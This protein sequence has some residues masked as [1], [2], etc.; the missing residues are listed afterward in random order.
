MRAIV[1][2]GQSGSGKTAIA[3][4]TA[5]KLS[6]NGYRVSYYKPLGFQKRTGK[7]EDDDVQLMKKVLG[8]HFSADVI[9]PVRLAPGYLSNLTN[10]TTETCLEKLDRCFRQLQQESQ[11][12][13]IEGSI[14]PFTGGSLGMDDYN[15]ALR[16]EAPVLHVIRADTDF[17]FDSALFHVNYSIN[18][19]IPILGCIFNNTLQAQWEKT[20]NLYKNLVE[21]MGIT[22]MG[23]LPHQ[24]VIA[25]PTVAEFY[26]A[27]GG[28][29]LIG[30][31]MLDRQVENIVVGAMT[32]ESALTYLRRSINTAVITGG[33]R[34][35]I[36]LTAL[37]TNTSVLIL[38][39]GHYP[40]VQIIARA[41]EKAVPVILV[42]YD[43]FTTLENLHTVYHSITPNSTEAIQ[44]IKNDS[45]RYLNLDPLLELLR[46]NG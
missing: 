26:Q 38:T 41:E 4:A 28:E 14:D 36:A 24:R 43:T 13:I 12:V 2:S 15:L 23:V 42:H 29:L 11:V 3:L 34:S 17:M 7:R 27:L 1:I 46:S 39:G 6:D 8:M 18:L 10:E 32:I 21:K 25:S 45:E 16:W 19:S 35:D 30:E 33:D 22:V 40:G 20:C 5:L 37:E 9:S 31:N 44:L